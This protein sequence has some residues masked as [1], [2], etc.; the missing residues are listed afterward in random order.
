MLAPLSRDHEG[1]Q[2]H[3]LWEL[4]GFPR[5]CGH[6]LGAVKPRRGVKAVGGR[7]LQVPSGVGLAR[8]CRAGSPAGST[9]LAAQPRP[10][11]GAGNSKARAAWLRLTGR[12][13]AGRTTGGGG[14]GSEGEGAAF[15]SPPGPP[16]PP[17]GPPPHSEAGRGPPRAGRGPGPR[18]LRRLA[19]SPPAPPA[20]ICSGFGVGGSRLS[21][22]SAPRA[23]GRPRPAP[24]DL[25]LLPRGLSELPRS[26]P[27]A[28]GRWNRRDVRPAAPGF[29]EDQVREDGRA[30]SAHVGPHGHLFLHSGL[31]H[32]LC[33]RKPL[34]IES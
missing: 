11:R 32:A 33:F 34:I 2:N 26:E 3:S 12:L 8:G 1:P 28:G 16:T 15:G 13:L 20:T 30:L 29:S 24:A 5:D 10:G 23:P 31:L 25:L 21:S 9:R 7:E 17:P 14:P 18:G 4:G 22:S 6:P 27:P 19:R